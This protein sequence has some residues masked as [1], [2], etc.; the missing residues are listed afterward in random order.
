MSAEEAWNSVGIPPAVGTVPRKIW[1]AKQYCAQVNS[2]SWPE[3]C[4]THSCL[5]K[6]YLCCLYKFFYKTVVSRNLTL[7]GKGRWYASLSC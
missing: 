5:I 3:P 2:F 4:L 1:L 7:F 6:L